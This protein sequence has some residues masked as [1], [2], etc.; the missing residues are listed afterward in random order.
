MVDRNLM[1][2]PIRRRSGAMGDIEKILPCAS[3]LP[4]GKMN[5]F[6]ISSTIYWLS[7]NKKIAKSLLKIVYVLKRLTGGFISQ[8]VMPENPIPATQPEAG[9]AAGE[10]IF[11]KPE[12]ENPRIKKRSL[13]AKPAGLIKPTA[14]ALPAARELEREAPP[15]SAEQVIK[16]ASVRT[17]EIMA[18]T[19]AKAAEAPVAPP[20]TTPATSAPARAASKTAASSASAAGPASSPHGTRPATLYYSSPTRKA[21]TPS[22]MKTIPTASP[23]S[24]SSAA[25]TSSAS[26]PRATGAAASTTTARPSPNVDYRANVERQSREQKS[27]GNILSYA[28]WVL[29]AFFLISAGLAGYGAHV[30]F[31]QLGDQSVTVSDLDK[32]YADANKDLTAK[33]S[34]TQDSLNQAQSQ[35]GRQQDVIV[36]QQ[37]EFNQLI[38]STTATDT[39]L[40]QER[41]ARAQEAANLR[42]RVKELE[43]KTTVQKY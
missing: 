38:T 20:R 34:A 6:L 8:G 32:K 1:Q 22:P 5:Q 19:T 18:K 21:E 7:C 27:V 14:A 9:A 15:L 43:Y 35:I 26:A 13:K 25:S 24:S 29:V 41:A 30:I 3:L 23:V 40:K 17:E 10:F 28:V 12:P 16:P 2:F 39:A 11:T 42:A 31:K 37:E 4:S 33:L 36:K